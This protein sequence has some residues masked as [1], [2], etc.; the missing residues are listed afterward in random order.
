M[1][2]KES[3][4]SR[5]IVSAV[6]LA[7]FVVTSIFLPTP[8]SSAQVPPGTVRKNSLS[9]P[10]TPALIK[11]VKVYQQDPFRFDFIMDKGHGSAVDAQ[12]QADAG[13]LI[14]YFL[15]SLTIPEKDMWVNLSPYEKGRIIPESFGQTEMGRDL[16]AQDFILKQLT[17]AL[18][19]PDNAIGKEFWSKVYAETQKLY[20]TI[21]VPVD[22]LSKVWI[23]PEKAVVYES[24]NTA[25]VIDGRLKVMLERDYSARFGSAVAGE[26]HSQGEFSD[27]TVTALREVI[28]PLLE[29]EVN[30]GGDFAQL[31]QVYHSLI[32]AAWFK[33]KLQNSL[34]GKAYVDRNKIRGV[35]IADKNE[36]E[37]IW[38]RYVDAF[39][40]GAYNIIKEDA[41]PQSNEVIPRKYFSGG[42]NMDMAMLQVLHDD[43]AVTAPGEPF[44]TERDVLQAWRLRDHVKPQDD[45]RKVI[46]ALMSLKAI[47]SEGKEE[48]LRDVL[49]PAF[50]VDPRAFSIDVVKGLAEKFAG[51]REWAYF[52]HYLGRHRDTPQQT[53]DFARA[54]LKERGAFPFQQQVRSVLSGTSREAMITA[55]E[56]VSLSDELAGP[57]MFVQALVDEYPDLQMTVLTRRPELYGH[58]RVKTVRVMAGDLTAASLP[59]DLTPRKYA[60]Q[61]SFSKKDLSPSASV[62]IKSGQKDGRFFL[63]K[64]MLDGRDLPK[65]MDEVNGDGAR[66]LDEMNFR[67]LAQLGLGIPV[68]QGRSSRQSVLVGQRSQA[69]QDMWAQMMESFSSPFD[70][71]K[72]RTSVVFFAPFGK[73]REDEGFSMQNRV[74]YNFVVS[75]LYEM[76]QA[77]MNVVIVPNKHSWGSRELAEK[78]KWQVDGWEQRAITVGPA[79]EDVPEIWKHLAS[80]ADYTV[81]ADKDIVSMFFQLGK[82][83]CV[84]NKT[85]MFQRGDGYPWF[86]GRHQL[87][88]GNKDSL[89]EQMEMAFPYGHKSFTGRGF[90]VLDMV[91]DLK[92]LLDERKG[93]ETSL[94]LVGVG[95]GVAAT[96]TAIKYPRVSIDAVNKEEGLW[97][98]DFVTETLLLKGYKEDAI[99]EA[100]SRIRKAAF[101]IEDA[102][103]RRNA[104][105]GRV[106]DMVLFE[107][108]TVMYLEDK[109]SAIQGLFNDFVKDGGVY[110]FETYY[111]GLKLAWGNTLE[112][113]SLLAKLISLVKSSLGREQ[114]PNEQE[115]ARIDWLLGQAFDKVSTTLSKK[116][117]DAGRTGVYSVVRR[118]GT[119][120][121]VI[122]ATLKQTEVDLRRGEMYSVMSH[123]EV[124]SKAVTVNARD[125]AM[126]SISAG[127]GVVV[128]VKTDMAM[129]AG[130]EIVVRDETGYEFPAILARV[131][132][133]NQLDEHEVYNLPDTGVRAG[134]ILERSMEKDAIAYSI[135]EKDYHWLLGY[136]VAVPEVSKYAGG[137][138][139]NIFVFA[140]A[141]Q[142][143][144]PHLFRHL[145]SA[146]AAE[147]RQLGY[148]RVSF[149]LDRQGVASGVYRLGYRGKVVNLIANRNEKLSRAEEEYLRQSL[150]R[151]NQERIRSQWEREFKE[152]IKRF[153]RAYIHLEVPLSGLDRTRTDLAQR[154]GEINGY[155]FKPQPG[156]AAGDPSIYKGIR[157]SEEIRG[158]L[159]KIKAA[160]GRLKIRLPV[161]ALDGPGSGIDK[162]DRRD[163]ITKSGAVSLEDIPS[164]PTFAHKD[165]YVDVFIEAADDP[166]AT[167]YVSDDY[168]LPAAKP[169]IVKGPLG[170]R[171]GKVELPRGIASAGAYIFRNLFNIAGIKLTVEV[172]HPVILAGS[173]ESSSMI[174]GAYTMAASMLKGA[175]LSYADIYHLCLKMENEVFEGATGGQGHFP[176]VLGGVLQNFWLSG[177]RDDDG[178]K[179]FGNE[180]FS[181]RLIL[182]KDYPFFEEHMAFVQMGKEFKDGKY[183]HPRTAEV[184][185]VMGG[186]LANDRDPVGLRLY[187][188]RV[189]LSHQFAQALLERDMKKVIKIVNRYMDIRDEI[190]YRWF[191]LALM[192]SGT[193][194]RPGYADKYAK[195][196]QEDPILK[197]FL[198]EF[199]DNLRTIS[200]YSHY[201]KDIIASAKKHRIGLFMVGGAGSNANAVAFAENKADL[202][203]FLREND[204]NLFDR[205]EATRIARGTGV[206]KGFM[207]F[208]IGGSIEFSDEFTQYGLKLPSLPSPA[209]LRVEEGKAEVFPYKR[210]IAQMN[211]DEMLDALPDDDRI[212]EESDD[213]VREEM[214]A[215][216]SNM[217]Q[218]LKEIQQKVDKGIIDLNNP[219]KFGVAVGTF[220]PV[221]WGHVNLWLEFVNRFNR[222]VLVS[223]NGDIQGYKD[224]KS[225]AVDRHNLAKLAIAP[226]S[227][228]ISYSQVGMEH[229]EL[230]PMAQGL[231][232]LELFKQKEKLDVLFIAGSDALERHARV[233]EDYLNGIA[234]K[235][236]IRFAVMTR[237]AYPIAEAAPSF[238][239]TGLSAEGIEGTVRG[240]K[241]TFPVTVIDS[242]NSL[243]SSLVRTEDKARVFLPESVDK[244]IVR[245]GIYVKQ[246]NIA[247]V[248]WM[249]ATHDVRPGV[250]K[251]IKRVVGGRYKISTGGF[252]AVD[253]SWKGADKGFVLRSVFEERP[254]LKTAVYF[255]NEFQYLG[256]DLSVLSGQTDLEAAGKQVVVFSVDKNPAKRTKE[257]RDR[258]VWIGAGSQATARVMK[259]IL[260][261]VLAGK[262]EVEIRGSGMDAHKKVI[263]SLRNFSDEFISLFDVD[264]TLLDKRD[265]GFEGSS[266]VR[267]QFIRM[268]ANGKVG[269]ISANAGAMQ[270]ERISNPLQRISMVENLFLYVNGGAT[271]VTFDRDGVAAT[272]NLFPDIPDEDVAKVQEIVLRSASEDFGLNQM[273]LAAWKEWFSFNGDYG[274]IRGHDD[275]RFGN[276]RFLPWWM[277]KDFRP[278]VIDNN[279]LE[280]ARFDT[281]PL[282]LSE[283]YLDFRNKVQLSVKFLPRIIDMN[284]DDAM[285]SVGGIDFK[286]VDPQVLDGVDGNEGEFKIDPRLW[287]RIEQA[288]G[289]VPVILQMTPLSGMEKV[290]GKR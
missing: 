161:R 175:D 48:L 248:R 100:L 123:Y 130:K 39:K 85:Q 57:V 196:L 255:G 80:F 87:V 15:A 241:M 18:L 34:L 89:P 58:P 165:L 24:G 237:T 283:P 251:Q 151:L 117:Y 74:D 60:L 105:Q 244:A 281:M 279:K 145:V 219:A 91:Y 174:L 198:E 157:T 184:T 156:V 274:V 10:F 253:I 199:G 126:K 264:G 25:V 78:L 275:V 176:Y 66:A 221:H 12:F 122:P 188:E 261:A 256:G 71:K 6:V 7:A 186:D 285:K 226:F 171:E 284:R 68:E 222:P 286:G 258:T 75:K 134:Q 61:M 33:R 133:G 270:M 254:V 194:G 35:D 187:Q 124:Q 113:R 211:F 267:S 120:P 153:P 62:F 64:F 268:L 189:V 77:G 40:K 101:D 206:L 9:L 67:L 3:H 278:D 49:E 191:E 83:Y 273:E 207:P 225:Q 218:N 144:Y 271:K 138:P 272:K 239:Q 232:H 90:D 118:Q 224:G 169:Y 233:A 195:F 54:A 107:H 213:S 47:P 193:P 223:P 93:E 168:N 16:L 142:R 170:M 148:K 32:L 162:E 234:D 65:V 146:V 79:M 190:N 185:S 141:V 173:V 4:P 96:E 13:R 121:L 147:A 197:G 249:Y 115:A 290:L 99:K 143:A 21:D 214:T 140:T 242:P 277:S 235:P 86:S 55:D 246:R 119:A 20:G 27:S 76:V 137:N 127:R 257:A 205:E 11:G 265:E 139:E 238:I 216:V 201:S 181:S 287:R 17:S 217:R 182:A 106:F 276:V 203:N 289:L 70:W 52:L 250:V 159:L 81:S 163:I 180:V 252:G 112:D 266:D 73:D 97:D 132:E 209:G 231:K 26:V 154:S 116:P 210:Q 92:R 183:V 2:L 155:W 135:K 59:P 128:S 109:F 172:S 46:P 45:V 202:K 72:G 82:P 220:D 114:S 240:S 63:D 98:D 178:K 166:D 150:D 50:F 84:L 192:K 280:Q 88:S 228:L 56:G 262:N 260:D 227:P 236:H 41:N 22:A 94:L 42:L 111:D 104:F 288:E 38:Q 95:R 44:N 51:E 8:Y 204:L 263:L 36:K 158:L 269:V 19:H 215:V 167:V 230:L 149:I 102:Q 164:T 53:R 37:K 259:E 282:Y 103:G 1:G 5:R 212:A 31:R 43:D 200:L 243:S 125:L 30:E 160:G 152:L 136:V 229:G 208:K 131:G 110:G 245:Q 179:W 129:A 177:L 69:A 29:K 14:K 108:S 247:K 23:V 28:I